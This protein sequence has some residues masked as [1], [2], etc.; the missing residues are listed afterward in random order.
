MKTRTITDINNFVTDY[1]KK[2]YIEPITNKET[3]FPIEVNP[4]G[5]KHTV[6]FIVK[7]PSIQ[8]QAELINVLRKLKVIIRDAVFIETQPDYKN[9]KDVIG[10]HIFKYENIEFIVREVIID[11]PKKINKLSFYNHRFIVEEIKNPD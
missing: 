10:I 7:K 3:K 6:S 9:R 1:V 5:I 8:E 4:R 11:K 2:K